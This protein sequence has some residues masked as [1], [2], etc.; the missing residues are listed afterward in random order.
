MPMPGVEVKLVDVTEL[1]YFTT[2]D[3]PRGE[4]LVKNNFMMSGY[5]KNEEET[6]KV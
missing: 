2:S 6:A 4:L 3:P 5:F 1:G